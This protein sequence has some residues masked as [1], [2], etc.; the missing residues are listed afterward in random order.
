MDGE[1]G[2]L[3]LGCRSEP[4]NVIVTVLQIAKDVVTEYVVK[5][6]EAIPCCDFLALLISAAVV[7]YWRLVDCTAQ[8]RN[9]R[10]DLDFKAEAARG[11]LH[12][13]NDLPAK[14]FVTGLDVCE[15]DIG[16]EV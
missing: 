5:S 8:L 3:D 15:V 9:F 12:L 10:G 13:P 4:R 2:W 7:T 16:G 6:C 1:L 14:R 11:Y